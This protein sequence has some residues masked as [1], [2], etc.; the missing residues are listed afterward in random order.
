MAQLRASC[1][2]RPTTRITPPTRRTRPALHH[3]H[4][5]APVTGARDEGGT[6]H[7]QIPSRPG[8]N[9]SGPPFQLGHS[10][11]QP[12]VQL[13]RPPA[14]RGHP[15]SR[16][17]AWL[18]HHF[19]QPLASTKDAPRHQLGAADALAGYQ[20]SV[21]AGQTGQLPGSASVWA[22]HLVGTA[23]EPTN[24]QS[25]SATQSANQQDGPA[26]GPASRPTHIHPRMYRQT[27]MS[28]VHCIYPTDRNNVS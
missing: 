25:E 16:P 12:N 28:H 18:G 19:G 2:Y 9:S 5:G 24:S 15:P 21:N 4:D 27:Q 8:P 7:R 22:D 10:F 26:D 17:I 13:G 14:P 1:C 23:A 20:P 3:R 11:G 6:P